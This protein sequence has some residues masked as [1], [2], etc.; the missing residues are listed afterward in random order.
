MTPR[1]IMS[2]ALR[3]GVRLDAQGDQLRIL[4]GDALPAAVFEE[5]RQA[6]AANKAGVLHELRLEAW[7]ELLAI[8]EYGAVRFHRHVGGGTWPEFPREVDVRPWTFEDSAH[9]VRVFLKASPLPHQ[10]LP[11]LLALQTRLDAGR[12]EVVQDMGGVVDDAMEQEPERFQC[13]W[14]K[15]QS[16]WRNLAGEPV[17]RDCHPPTASV[18][19]FLEQRAGGR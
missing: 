14:C 8:V 3:L 13:L 16:F 12:P 7:R 19:D 6:L 17:C 15:G 10:R 11:E 18:R 5:L 4:G 9:V 2:E 1:E